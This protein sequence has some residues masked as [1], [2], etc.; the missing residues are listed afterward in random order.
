MYLY[1]I[2]L[3]WLNEATQA[4]QLWIDGPTG[5]SSED[6]IL[7]VIEPSDSFVGSPAIFVR[8]GDRTQVLAHYRTII[9][10]N[11]A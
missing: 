7:M 4:F 5:E 11:A 1:C 3:G 9:A 8:G 6:Q 10:A 2:W